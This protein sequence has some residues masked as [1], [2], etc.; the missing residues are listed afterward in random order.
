MQG[1]LFVY[2][3]ESKHTAFKYG[4]S[5]TVMILI[6][7]MFGGLMTCDYWINLSKELHEHGVGT[8]QF[9]MSSSY[10]QFGI[11]S[12]KQYEI[13]KIWLI[14]RDADEIELLI[15]YLLSHYKIDKFHLL[16]HST[17]C[18]D[19]IKFLSV[20]KYSNLIGCC[21]L[22]GPA[23]DREST[24]MEAS[25]EEVEKYLK[26]SKEYIDENKPNK[27]MPTESYFVPITAYRFYSLNSKFGDDDMF[28]SDFTNEDFKTIFKH[29]PKSIKICFIE[30]EN[31]EFIPNYVNKTELIERMANSVENGYFYL[32]KGT[33][34]S[35]DKNEEDLIKYIINFL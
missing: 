16:G 17:G 27:L 9:I 7:G 19:I 28:S 14:Y 26:I 5:S 29:I 21:F 10:S 30:S 12:L 2:N 8:V 1:E 22:Q 24:L 11:S 13:N 15:T 31:D 32:L 25:K 18:Q 23:S 4:D 33:N 20:T 35:V 3:N 6:G 34:H